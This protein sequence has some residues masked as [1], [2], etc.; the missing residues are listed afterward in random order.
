MTYLDKL[1]NDYIDHKAN[2]CLICDSRNISFGN[3]HCGMLGDAWRTVKCQECK[4][5]WDQLF[6][7]FDITFFGI[8]E[9]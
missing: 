8:A 2:K 3:F 4:S 7:L 5:Q 9:D 1:K 6:E